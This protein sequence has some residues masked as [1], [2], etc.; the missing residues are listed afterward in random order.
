MGMKIITEKK[1]KKN[2]TMR[3]RRMMQVQM[4]NWVKEIEIRKEKTV[5][6]RGRNERV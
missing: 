5:Q 6:I 4:G 2:M 3:K 1:E